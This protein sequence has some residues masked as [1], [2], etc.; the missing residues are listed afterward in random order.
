[1]FCQGDMMVKIHNQ[2]CV[3]EHRPAW[4]QLCS[5]FLCHHLSP[6][7]H[8]LSAFNLISFTISFTSLKAKILW[9]GLWNIRKHNQHCLENRE[10]QPRERLPD[11]TCIE[12]TLRCTGKLCGDKES[13][14]PLESHH[15]EG[16]YSELSLRSKTRKVRLCI[17][18]QT[19]GCGRCGKGAQIKFLLTLTW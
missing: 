4:P 1:M 9:L 5:I 7:Q 3:L 16:N 14:I 19:F 6:G 12:R 8:E 2:R 11:K 17:L 13:C 18:L 10:D 15:S